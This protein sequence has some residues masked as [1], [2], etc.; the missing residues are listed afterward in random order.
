[1]KYFYKNIV[2]S[3]ILLFIANTTKAQVN[4]QFNCNPT[5]Y[6]LSYAGT[7]GFGGKNAY[8]VYQDFN[9]YLDIF[10]YGPLSQWHIDGKINGN[11][12]NFHS[13]T[14]TSPN[15]PDFT[16]ANWTTTFGP[17]N[18]TQVN[19]PSTTN[20]NATITQTNLSCSTAENGSATMTPTGGTPPYTYLWSP[21][22]ETGATNVYPFTPGTYTCVATDAA[23]NSI[24]KSVTITS[25]PPPDNT[26]TENNG[27]L[28]ATQ[29]TGVSYQ[30]RTC[31]DDDIPGATQQ[32]YTPTVVGDYMV[33][34]EEPAGCG[35][36]SNCIT[37]T[38]LATNSFDIA[39]K[40]KLYP[41]PAQ[42]QVT[43]EAN[44]LTNASLQIMDI[45]GRVLQNQTLQNTN[46]IN[47]ENL[48][49]GVYLFKISSQE[50][51]ST[52]RVVKN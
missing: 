27:V 3:T 29:A 17:C 39:N 21:S 36:Y 44:K 43:I 2:L 20:L 16:I 24:T 38:T 30:W 9:N 28:T 19:G 25:P 41:N 10:W 51:S 32:S 18:V 22:G 23:S 5:V 45:N 7:G 34:I 8:S 52:Q 6:T 15:P 49:S 26:I 47:I 33:Y 1:M 13:S 31:T 35:Y 37:V 42:N 48:Q 11:S 12:V 40:L 4:I 14:N 50:G 46:T